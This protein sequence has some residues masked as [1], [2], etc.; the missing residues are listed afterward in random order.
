MYGIVISRVEKNSFQNLKY[1]FLVQ[2][3]ISKNWLLV[4]NFPYECVERKSITYMN[5]LNFKKL[6]E[7]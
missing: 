7:I 5:L 3:Y 6:L 1:M 4:Q 2:I